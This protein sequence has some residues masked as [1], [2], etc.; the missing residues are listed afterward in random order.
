M[1]PV[2]PKDRSPWR[3]GLVLHPRRDCSL[4]ARLV[5]DWAASHGAQVLVREADLPRCPGPARPVTPE[6]LAAQVDGIVSLG[7]DGTMLGALR[8]AAARPVPV[9]GVNLGHLGFLVEVGPDEVPEALDRLERGDYG[10]ERHPCLVVRTARGEAVAFNDVALARVPGDGAVQATLAVA[11]QR[12]GRYRCDALILATPIGSTAYSY[13]AGGPIVSPM[14]DAVVVS[15]AAPMAGVSRPLV[16]SSE[17][18]LG[19]ELLEESGRPALEL[20]GE[21]R[22][23]M[24][25]GERLDVHVRRDAGQ[26]VRLDADRYRRRNQ[27]KLSLLDLPFQAEELRELEPGDGRGAEAP[28]PSAVDD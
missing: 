13:A 12:Y 2:L 8:L 25:P 16:V 5:A 10:V 11:G 21:V 27:L 14:V 1:S 20:D 6:A 19:L 26:V 7:G 15:A 23:H 4:P 9:L 22:R 18:A 24:A 17:E 3:L 28:R